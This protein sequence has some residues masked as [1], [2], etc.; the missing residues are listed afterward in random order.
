MNNTEQKQKFE[1]EHQAGQFSKEF[2]FAL[3]NL[4]L[5][6]VKTFSKTARFVKKNNPF[7]SE[8]FFFFYSIIYDYHEKYDDVPDPIVITQEINNLGES[9]NLDRYYTFF[10]KIQNTVDYNKDYIIEQL[11]PFIK[12]FYFADAYNQMPDKYN[13]NPSEA[14]T[15]LNKLVE[16]INS[17][18]FEAEEDSFLTLDDYWTEVEKENQLDNKKFAA[19]GIFEFDKVLRGGVRAGE[20]MTFLAKD[21]VGKSMCLMNIGA[22]ALEKG[23]KVLHFHCEGK[24]NQ[25]LFRYISR[26]TKINYHNV[27]DRELTKEEEQRIGAMMETSGKNLKIRP[28]LNTGKKNSFGVTIEDLQAVCAEVYETFEF[29]VLI[30][31][32]GDKLNTKMPTEANRFISDH[33]WRGLEEIGAK[34]NVPVFT[35]T[36]SVRV[37]GNSNNQFLTKEDSSESMYKSRLSSYVVS[38]NK[39][40]QDAAENKIRFFMSK[41]REEEANLYV[42][43]NSDFSRCITHFPDAQVKMNQDGE[44]D[45]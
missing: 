12:A 24:R 17:I 21:G 1:E 27:R 22:I 19:T 37:K 45:A 32:Y 23:K 36:Q 10:E 26:L 5:K 30:V 25:P 16:D 40:E 20:I 31:D 34:F 2:Q 7:E 11:E 6:D 15:A 39:S 14:Y 4:F 8:M 41:N 9:E 29:D 44:E 28:F 3:L 42:K 38:I 18:T 13:K 35:A 33:V 43:C